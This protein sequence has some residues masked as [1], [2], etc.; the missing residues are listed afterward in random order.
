MHGFKDYLPAAGNGSSTDRDFNSMMKS[1]FSTDMSG[2]HMSASRRIFRCS[3]CA[4]SILLLLVSASR[5]RPDESKASAS[6]V[7]YLLR[8]DRADR[9]SQDLAKQPCWT[10]PH[11][12]GVFLRTHWNKIQPNPSA[13]NWSFIDQGVSL[14]ARYHKKVGLLVTAGVTTPDWVYQAGAERF[15]V[16]GPRQH[17]ASSEMTQPLPWDRVFKEKWGAVI[18]EM[19][20]RYD[21]NPVVAYVVM[22]G[23][24]RRA[25]SFFASTP[26]DIESFVRV[27]GLG[28]WQPAVKWIIDQYS[29]AFKRTPFLLD[30]G[31][32]VPT[33]E[34]RDALAAVCHYGVATYPQRFGVKSDGLTANYN[35]AA[36]G[37]T[38]ISKLTKVT[39]VGFQ[40]S[41][42]SKGKAA[43]Q[44]G[45]LLAA[46]LQRGI[47][48]GAHFIEVYAVDCNN[49]SEAAAL[50]KASE[51]LKKMTRR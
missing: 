44:G 38:E 48:L 10:N 12:D 24:G 2:R 46:A 37:A 41:V 5:A 11:V 27:G 28:S 9:P 35:L 39:T 20:S 19:G 8:A 14:A 23:S 29:Q 32:P 40:M 42:P 7:I 25:E 21:G 36:F 34:G 13:I 47:S 51:E 22:A 33:A 1:V 30:L 15:G 3:L 18:R 26:G 17:V 6:G 16:H 45:S 43:R 50:D 49:P 4:I 31:A